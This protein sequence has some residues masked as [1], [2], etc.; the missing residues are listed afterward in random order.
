[1]IESG[2]ARV[3]FLWQFLSESFDYIMQLFKTRNPV[4]ATIMIVFFMWLQWYQFYSAAS[5]GVWFW[6]V[7]FGF[8]FNPELKSHLKF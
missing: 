3:F 8:F 5:G 2:A 7:L 1:M 6:F 4:F